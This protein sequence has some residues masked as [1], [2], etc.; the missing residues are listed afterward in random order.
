VGFFYWLA[1][2]LL[3]EPGNLVAVV[4][5]DVPLAWTD[6][7]LRIGGASLLGASVTPLLLRLTRRLPIE[8][9]T[10][11]RRASIHAASVLALSMLL[12]AVA[13]VLAQFLLAGRDPRLQ[14]SLTDELASNG[15]LLILCMAAFTAIAHATR[16]LRRAETERALAAAATKRAAEGPLTRVPVKTRGGVFLLPLDEVDWI[17]TQGNYLA[18]HAGPKT[19]LIRET[20]ARFESGLDPQRFVRIHRR[21]IVQADRVRELT[22]LSNG[23]AS[24]RLADG[25]ELRM[26]RGFSAQAHAM[27]A[28]K[29]A[30]RKPEPA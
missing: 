27:F 11:R 12:I 29:P 26:S 15:A 3:L 5:N 1:F 18:L 7:V 4:R 8:G 9:P 30:T 2:L 16:F 19:H 14:G 6:E 25:S 10:W 17:E 24:V 13:Q 20:L 28:K 21:T 23:D 22:H